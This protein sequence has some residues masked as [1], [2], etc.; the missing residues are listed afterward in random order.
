MVI[1]PA[2]VTPQVADEYSIQANQKITADSISIVN[3]SSKADLQD[4]SYYTSTGGSDCEIVLDHGENYQVLI[5]SIR[6]FPKLNLETD[7]VGDTIKGS[8][9]G[10]TYTLLHTLEDN[11]IEN[12]NT[13]KVPAG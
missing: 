3:G 9:D 5:D 11:L 2:I 10:T 6:M 7:S 4:G 13:F 8:N 12:W 1:T